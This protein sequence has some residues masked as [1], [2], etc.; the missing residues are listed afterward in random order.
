VAT[1]RVKFTVEVVEE[2]EAD[3]IEDAESAFSE[4]W[5]GPEDIVEQGV[6]TV[7]EL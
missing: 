4:L 2:V 1:Y 5:S 6:Y 3:S 7:E